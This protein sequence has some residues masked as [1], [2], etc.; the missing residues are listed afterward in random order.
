[1]QQWNGIPPSCIDIDECTSNPCSE[2]ATCIN[3]AGSFS[4]VCL[5]NYTGNFDT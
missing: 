2:Y 3:T 5:Q 1:M 4:C